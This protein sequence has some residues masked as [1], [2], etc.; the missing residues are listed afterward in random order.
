[1]AAFQSLFMALAID[2]I[3][4]RGPSN[5]TSR[6]LQPKKSYTSRSY[7]SKRQFTRSS[8]LTETKCFSFKSE[9]VVRV[10]NNEM[11][12]QL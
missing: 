7:S 12:C 9:C 5:E 6:Q 2:V 1:M 4:R 11:R 3:D 10:E 8:S